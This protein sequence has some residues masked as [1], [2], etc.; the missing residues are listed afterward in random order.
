MELQAAS[1]ASVDEAR[2]PSVEE[3]EPRP[4]A[5]GAGR[6]QERGCHSLGAAHAA[7]AEAP[8]RA[9][10]WLWPSRQ[11]MVRE[12][13][14]LREGSL[15]KAPQDGQGARQ[16]MVR[17]PD[18]SREGSLEK[19]R[20]PAVDGSREGSLEKVRL[21]GL[22]NDKT[23]HGKRSTWVNCDFQQVWARERARERGRERVRECTHT[24]THNMI[25]VCVCVCV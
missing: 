2:R 3:T 19:V 15:E 25:D 22:V 24:R 7:C 10:R 11:R 4:R 6:H 16:R 14:G 8:V 17:E 9:W 18:G 1:Q 21:P 23:S 5:G 20:L 12:P 13:D